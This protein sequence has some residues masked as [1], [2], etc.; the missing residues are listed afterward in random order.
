M[1]RQLNWVNQSSVDICGT[2]AIHGVGCRL[3]GCDAVNNCGCLPSL[4]TTLL[5]QT[6]D[7]KNDHRK[8]SFVRLLY[9]IARRHI[10]INSKFSLQNKA[11]LRP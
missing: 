4:A 10:P 9:Q 6:L 7:Y 5:R 2:A 3:L 1:Y 8:S 11:L